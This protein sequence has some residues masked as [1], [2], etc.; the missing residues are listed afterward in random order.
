M[1]RRGRP[2]S[3]PFPGGPGRG[4]ELER[5][6]PAGRQEAAH[7]SRAAARGR[8]FPPRADI[9]G[10]SSARGAADLPRPRAPLTPASAPPGPGR[11]DAPRP[12]AREARVRVLARR[13][14]SRVSSRG[15]ETSAWKAPERVPQPPPPPILS[16][17]G[18]PR[19]SLTVCLAQSLHTVKSRLQGDP[20][21]DQRKPSWS[22]T[23]LCKRAAQ[24]GGTTLSGVEP[25]LQAPMRMAKRVWRGNTCSR[26]SS[27][28][29]H[30]ADILHLRAFLP[31][32][33]NTAIF[34]GVDCKIDQTNVVTDMYLFKP[35]LHCYLWRW[36]WVKCLAQAGWGVGCGKVSWV[37][38]R[39]C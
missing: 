33:R 13:R 7:C 14:P 11:G 32:L 12:A 30:H 18:W 19:C 29:L 22:D 37:C 39:R 8:E 26:S 6:R 5:G 25:C 17:L 10:E 2:G 36:A 23:P 3:G 24:G 35:A 15:N 27:T 4:A 9:K 21:T 16:P 1:Y 38:F 31:G 34:V 28:E 20:P